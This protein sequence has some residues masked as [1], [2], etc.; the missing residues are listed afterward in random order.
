MDDPQ[1]TGLQLWEL[2]K[3]ILIPLGAYL[4]L[5]H[6]RLRQN[7]MD[8]KLHTSETYV[9][10]DEYASGFEKIERELREIR[11]ILQD[12]AQKVPR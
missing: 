4:L 3:Y 11:R 8:H 6:I 7:L 5:S 12:M 9:T 1:I 10:K 2:T